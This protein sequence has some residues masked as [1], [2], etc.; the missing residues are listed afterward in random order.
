MVHGDDQGL[1]LPPGSRRSRPSSFRSGARPRSAKQVLAAARMCL[2]ALNAAGIRA[3]LDDREGATPGFKFNDWE[4]RGVP[5]RVEIGP[6]DVASGS[7]DTGA[8]RHPGP[9]KP[10]SRRRSPSC[11]HAVAATARR[12]SG[13]SID[14]ARAAMAAETRTF[15]DYEALRQ[16]DGRR[17]RRR[18]RRTPLVRR[19]G[20]RNP[21][22]E[23]TKATCRAIPLNQQG[24][25]GPCIICGNAGEKAFFAK[26]Y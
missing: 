23:E 17:R 1:R 9:R 4:M 2:A 7:G 22:R 21:I 6:R 11:R 13:Q 16:T 8:A 24:P 20:L 3:H 14:Q 15:D 5:V 25:S 18:L 12:D 26:S 19:P 10:R